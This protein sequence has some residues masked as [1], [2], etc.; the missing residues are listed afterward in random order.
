MDSGGVDRPVTCLTFTLGGESFG[1]DV[2][3]VKEVLD[4][5]PITRVPRSG[6]Y[7]RGVINLRGMV[8][9]VMDLSDK[10]GMPRGG[11]E[12]NP[13][14]IVVEMDQ[15]GEK[16]AAGLLA[17]AVQE[18]VEVQPDQIEPAPALGMPLDRRFI[19]GLA[20]REGGLLVLLDLD[21]VFSSD[22]IKVADP[23]G[24]K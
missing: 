19:R 6:P 5:V 8:I 12:E 2:A 18:V 16:T 22:E 1:V 10:L 9:P 7:M 4:I 13:C 11:G 3:Q 17:D 21:Q 23:K 24:E 20:K 14:I 15:D